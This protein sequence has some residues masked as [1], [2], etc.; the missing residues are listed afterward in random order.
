MKTIIYRLLFVIPF[1]INTAAMAQGR[2]NI[3][4]TIADEKGQPIKSATVFISGSQKI[5]ITDDEGRFM[6]VNMDAGT[7]QVSV[8]MLGYAPYAQ[9]VMIKAASATINIALTLRP[10]ALNVVVIG[11][12]DDSNWWTYYTLFKG[13]FIGTST[14]AQ[15][16]TILNPRMLHLNYN[17]KKGILLA[18]ADRFLIIENKFLGYRIKYMLKYFEYNAINNATIYDGDTNF[19][20]LPG[21]AG[22]KKRWAKNR[23]EAYRGSLMHFLRSVY[24]K[25]TLQEGFIVNTLYKFTYKNKHDDGPTLSVDARPIKF[26]SLITVID[27]SFISLKFSPIYVTYNPKKAVDIKNKGDYLTMKDMA[28]NDKASVIKLPLKEA[29]IDR[30]GS[31]VNY[32]AF[33]FNGDMGTKRIGD[34]LPFEYQPNN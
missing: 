7:F 11:G 1:F 17:K 22:M 19:E 32:R 14:N 16:C 21:T 30:K 20:E 6:F 3:S 23:E 33:V 15:Q 12:G 27:S 9:N 10:I 18:D 8:Q 5:T 26:D 24:T 28:L 29:V 31:Y 2:Y 4:G 13:Q 25:T 34:Q